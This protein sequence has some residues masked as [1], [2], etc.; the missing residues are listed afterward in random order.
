MVLD[1]LRLDDFRTSGEDDRTAFTTLINKIEITSPVSLAAHRD[2]AAQLCFLT[3][4]VNGIPWAL[5]SS[6]QLPSV[7]SYSDLVYSLSYALWTLQLRDASGA[8]PP[9]V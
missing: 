9:R 6:F 3:R 4:A 7:H 2:S 1:K 8:L 5:H